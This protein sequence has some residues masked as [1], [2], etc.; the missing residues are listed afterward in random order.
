MKRVRESALGAGEVNLAEEAISRYNATW[1]GF[2]SMI[3]DIRTVCPLLAMART[4]V[5]FTISQKKEIY[6]I[7]QKFVEKIV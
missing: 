1:E 6:R 5:C 7:P 2:A 3:T 4:Q